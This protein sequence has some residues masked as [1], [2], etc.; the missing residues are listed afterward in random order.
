M[1]NVDMALPL[2]QKK[3]IKL[4]GQMKLFYNKHMSWLCQEYDVYAIIMT[5][6]VIVMTSWYTDI[7]LHILDNNSWY[8]ANFTIGGQYFLFLSWILLL[9]CRT[10]KLFLINI[11]RCHWQDH[12]TLAKTFAITT[13]IGTKLLNRHKLKVKKMGFIAVSIFVKIW[14]KSMRVQLCI[15]DLLDLIR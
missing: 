9:L 2:K 14:K 13:K 12:H 10:K 7:I 15:K 8:Y 5:S 4:L 3:N 1:L 11:H 6:Y